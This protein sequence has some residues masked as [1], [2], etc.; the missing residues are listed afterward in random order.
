MLTLTYLKCLPLQQM[1]NK[2]KRNVDRRLAKKPDPG[3]SAYIL[4][5][6]FPFDVLDSEIQSGSGYRAY[7]GRMTPKV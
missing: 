1:S 4:F 2:K 3:F 5:V 7:R 6:S